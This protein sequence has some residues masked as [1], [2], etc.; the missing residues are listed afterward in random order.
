MEEEKI[1]NFGIHFIIILC[2][3]NRMCKYVINIVI[4][5][6]VICI[7][8]K[9]ELG[10]L[11]YFLK[12][13]CILC[14]ICLTFSCLFPLFLPFF[15]C[16]LLMKTIITVDVNFSISLSIF[17]RKMCNFTLFLQYLTQTL[18]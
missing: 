6:C 14:V 17:I 7:L 16:I 10:R 18:S 11:R 1:K 8:R 15:F 5:L 13:K 2:E 3:K 4:V 12:I 9:T